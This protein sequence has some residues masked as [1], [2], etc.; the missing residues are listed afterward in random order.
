[1]ETDN[2]IGKVIFTII[3]QIQKQRFAR[4][5]ILRMVSSEQQGKA[6]AEQGMS[7]VLWDMFTGSAPYEK[8]FLRTLHPTFWMRFLRD[9]VVSSWLLHRGGANSTLEASR[10]VTPAPDAGAGIHNL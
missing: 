9:L 4:A 8:V 1:V 7:L 6:S 3:R 2:F 10:S 5:A